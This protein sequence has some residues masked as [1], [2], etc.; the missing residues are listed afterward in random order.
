MSRAR[1]FSTAILSAAIAL[2]GERVEA[3]SASSITAA[4]GVVLP[5][6]ASY[7]NMSLKDLKFG[8]GVLIAANGTATGDVLG[9]L[10]G[11][12]AGRVWTITLEGNATT[13]SARVGG[14]GNLSGTCSLDMG[15]GMP[16]HA[17]VPF[18]L[19][20]TRRPDGKWSVLMTLGNTQLPAAIVSAGSITVR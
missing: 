8:I 3:Q 12:Y 15:T 14:P 6:S 5:S 20:F 10:R 1:I 17:G 2:S 13:G 16:A 4:G 9:T 11:T 7:A 19:A 18:A